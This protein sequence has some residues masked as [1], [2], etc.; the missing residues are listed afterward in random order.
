MNYQQTIDYLFTR[1]PMFSR[2]GAQCHKKRYH[3][4]C[5]AYV[6]HWV[7]RIRNSKRFILQELTERVQSAICWQLFYKL[8]AIRPDY[9]PLR[10]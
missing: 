1:L 10:I 3:Q 5:S 2:I 4:Y 7:I 8:P 6:N 9:T